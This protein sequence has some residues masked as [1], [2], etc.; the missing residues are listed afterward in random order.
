VAEARTESAVGALGALPTVV[1]C[2]TV[3][4]GLIPTELI[5]E[6]RKQYLRPGFKLVTLW[7]KEFEAVLER[8][9]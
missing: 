7:A 5:V 8:V 2:K 6:T 1:S 4:A 3:E 9:V